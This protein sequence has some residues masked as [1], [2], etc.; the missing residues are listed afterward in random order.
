VRE[1]EARGWIAVESATLGET[2][3]IVDPGAGFRSEI[4]DWLVDA[5]RYTTDE[6]RRLVGVDPESLRCLHAFKRAG[7]TIVGR[8]SAAEA[9]RVTA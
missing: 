9:E 8:E 4:P 2:I 5:I 1:L 3:V 7:A 6:A